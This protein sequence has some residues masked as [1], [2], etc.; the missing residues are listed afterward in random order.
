MK[1]SV[2]LCESKMRFINQSFERT[3]IASLK[4]N[5]FDGKTKKYMN[6]KV[7]GK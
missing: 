7:K 2:E 3:I 4:L 5:Q 6:Q 1:W